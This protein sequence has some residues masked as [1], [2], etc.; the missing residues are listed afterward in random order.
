MFAVWFETHLLSTH[1][2][3]RVMDSRTEIQKLTQKEK[4]IAAVL[5]GW[6]LIHLVLLFISDGSTSYFWP[7][8]EKPEVKVDYDFSE[9]FVYGVIPWVIFIAYRFMNKQDA[10]SKLS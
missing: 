3:I 10:S 1:F 4:M 2:K 7:L 9:F 5:I 6:T 8:D